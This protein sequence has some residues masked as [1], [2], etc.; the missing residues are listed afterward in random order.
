MNYAKKQENLNVSAY[1]N[2]DSRI[3][4]NAIGINYLYIQRIGKRMKEEQ[5]RKKIKSLK[6]KISQY[7]KAIFLSRDEIFFLQEQIFKIQDENLN[8]FLNY[9]TKEMRHELSI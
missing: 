7:E 3:N 6:D 1:I 2:G 9:N 8:A 5:I 4:I